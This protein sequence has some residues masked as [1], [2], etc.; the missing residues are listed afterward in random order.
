MSISH[1]SIFMLGVII[2]SLAQILLKKSAM[3]K[4]DSQ[5]KEYLN[6]K[7]ILGYFLIFSGTVLAII[8]YQEIEFKYGTMMHST[9]VIFVLIFEM[10]FLKIKPTRHRIIGVLIIVAG[11]G[12]FIS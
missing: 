3:G 1:A 11:V 8:A 10:M 6:S 5:I 9:G 12:V 7:V 2:S 4:H